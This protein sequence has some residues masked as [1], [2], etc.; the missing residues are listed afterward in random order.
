MCQKAAQTAGALMAGL[1]PEIQSLLTATGLASTAAGQ[2]A[3]TAYNTAATDLQNWKSGTAA[4]DVIEALND[5]EDVF[6]KLPLPATFELFGN[7]ILGGIVTIIGIVT[8]NSPAPSTTEEVGEDAA[9]PEETQAHYQAQVAAD[10]TAKVEALVPG[11]KRS[12]FHSA[13]SQQ[14]SA[15]NKA[16]DEN[17]GVG[18]SKV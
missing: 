17:P 14:K 12:I 3:L 18:V 11:F 6:N 10:T 2:A 15:W 5:L 8:A 7:I 4:Q 9:T 13:A 1:E 16:V